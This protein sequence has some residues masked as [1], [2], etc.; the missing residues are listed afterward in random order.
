MSIAAEPIAVATI[1]GQSSGKEKA[2]PSPSRRNYVVKTDAV[3]VPEA[4]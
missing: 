2:R 3:V 1:G 4:R